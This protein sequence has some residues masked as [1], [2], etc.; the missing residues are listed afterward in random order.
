MCSQEQ[1][2]MI[3]DHFPVATLHNNKYQNTYLYRA[4]MQNG[5]RGASELAGD[6]FRDQSGSMN[7][8]FH[9]SPTASPTLQ[10]HDNEKNPLF[11]SGFLPPRTGWKWWRYHEMTDKEILDH[12][13]NGQHYDKREKPPST[14]KV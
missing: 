2:V 5:Q 11:P 12:L 9:S 1:K 7:R 3:T 4:Q 13:L 14:G 10:D 6:I 8:N